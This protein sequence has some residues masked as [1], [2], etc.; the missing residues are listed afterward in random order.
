MSDIFDHLDN[1]TPEEAWGDPTKVNGSLLL[2]LQAIRTYIAHGFTVHNAYT[3][4]GHAPSSQH[5]VGNA[6]D[7]HISG[8][9][10]Y[11]AVL[12]VEEALH[13]YQVE[14]H[15]GLGI[16]PDWNTPGFH[17]DVRGTKARWGRIGNDYVSYEQ[18]KEYA[19]AKR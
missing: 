11:E 12:V 3:H 13:F 1:F 18:A 9:P 5:Y 4:T 8:I 2:L 17:L 14:E 7:F 19:K 10:F 16:Y 15:V 6:V